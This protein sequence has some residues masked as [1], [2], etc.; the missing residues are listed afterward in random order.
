MKNHNPSSIAAPVASYSH[1]IEVP[2]QARTLVLAG[3]VG[4]TPDGKIT[5]GIVAQTEQAWRNIG[6]ILKSANMD[7]RD[8]IRVSTFLVD[9]DDYAASSEIRNQVLG[10][11]APAMTLLVVKS[12]VSP[13]FRIEIECVAA[14]A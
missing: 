11:H 4:I 5:E 6:A 10:D 8:L 1:G 3:Q 9:L 12:L 7:Y 2:P 14:R 13:E